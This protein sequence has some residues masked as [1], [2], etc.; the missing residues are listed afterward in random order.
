[1]LDVMLI[2]DATSD[3]WPAIWPFLR[4]IVAAGETFTW[5][6]D[7]SEE[8]ARA[9]W[10]LEPPSRTVVAV[11]PDQA[12]L[13]TAKMNPNHMG[14]ASHISSAS[15]MVDPAHAGRGVGRALGE[16]V[17]DWARGEGYRAMQ[18][19]AV[20]ETNTRAVALWRSLGFEVLA[21]LPEGFKHPAEGY[22]G[23]H[24]MYRPL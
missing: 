21:T 12:I 6:R 2:R 16:H 23:L 19:N 3:D 9:M 14:P 1:M 10:L 15:F 18:F 17:L 8:R 20:V 11:G 24:I 4:Q 7:V 13:G 5:D 22:V